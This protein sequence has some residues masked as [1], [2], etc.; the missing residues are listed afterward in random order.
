MPL[1]IV[2]QSKSIPTP[3]TLTGQIDCYSDIPHKRSRFALLD[4]VGIHQ[5]ALLSFCAQQELT[6]FIQQKHFW[7]SLS[8]LV[9]LRVA[10]REG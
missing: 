3:A 4:R 10:A 5:A 2:L 7:H 6:L 9:S 8:D 1:A